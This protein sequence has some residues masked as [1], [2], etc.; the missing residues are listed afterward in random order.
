MKSFLTVYSYNRKQS[1]LF[2]TVNNEP[3]MTQQSD[4]DSTDINIIMK[5]Y[6]AT[7]QMPTVIEPGKYGDFSQV[8]DY[9]TA[10]DTLRHADEKFLDVPAEIRKQFNHNPAEFFEFVNNPANKDKMRTM[11]LLT[12][13]PAPVPSTPPAPTP[14]PTPTT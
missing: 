12:E 14:T 1:H 13:A 3:S 8:T 6:G 7:G 5:R 11:G 10:L 4:R 2:S 9:R